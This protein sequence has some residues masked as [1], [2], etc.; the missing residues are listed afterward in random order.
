MLPA[1]VIAI[2]SALKSATRFGTNS[3]KTK[4]KYQLNDETINDYFN[5]GHY[6]EKL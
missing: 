4:E 3:P 1:V 6:R 2:S 5:N